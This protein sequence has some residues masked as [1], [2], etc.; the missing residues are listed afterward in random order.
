MSRYKNVRKTTNFFKPYYQIAFSKCVHLFMN[1]DTYINVHNNLILCHI[2]VASVTVVPK[3]RIVLTK[4]RQ[5]IA[6]FVPLKITNRNFFIA[7]PAIVVIVEHNVS[8]YIYCI[9]RKK[10]HEEINY[11]TK[12]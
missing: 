9:F 6:P 11:F 12:A 4:N 1:F 3:T 5:I 10:P 7:L 2:S 8:A